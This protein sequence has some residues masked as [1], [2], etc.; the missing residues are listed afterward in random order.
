MEL[1]CT[2]EKYEIWTTQQFY[3]R[4]EVVL[5]KII[6]ISIDFVNNCVLDYFICLS[7]HS[8]IPYKSDVIIV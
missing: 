3:E 4:N 8:V 5:Y 7:T 2:W 6:R 1:T